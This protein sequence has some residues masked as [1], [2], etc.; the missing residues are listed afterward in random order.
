[1]TKKLAS[2]LLIPLLFLTLLLTACPSPEAADDDAVPGNQSEELEE[3]EG[4]D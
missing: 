2:Y 4:E 1:M 3:A